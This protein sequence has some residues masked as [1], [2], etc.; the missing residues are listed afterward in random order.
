ME[1]GSLI[2]RRLDN[3]VFREIRK[4]DKDMQMGAGIGN[5]YS[6]VEGMIVADGTGD[7]PLISWTKAL[8]NYSCSMGAPAGARITMMLP[9]ATKES[10]IKGCMEEY[11]QLATEC[12]I[13]I[14]GGHTQVSDS[15]KNPFFS[16][17][18]F[19]RSEWHPDKKTVADGSGIVM[20]GYAGALGTDIL[21]RDNAELIRNRFGNYFS[22][23]ASGRGYSV[24]EAAGVAALDAAGVAYVHDIS[25]GG[26]YAALWQLGRWADCGFTVYND[27]IAINQET[28]EVCEALDKNPYLID[29]TGGLLIVTDDPEALLSAMDEKGI[30]ARLIG[31]IQ[32]GGERVVVFGDNEQRTL[33]ASTGD[34][35]WKETCLDR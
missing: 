6:A 15:F 28:I 24:R 20:C 9:V 11:Q 1:I 22:K 4:I 23:R 26:V 7:T 16:V 29:G 27:R 33:A 17:Q 13:Q 8:N 2:E 19:G 32:K 30:V 31:R 14:A 25:S 10:F 5:D 34:E 35:I 12:G 18:I 21:L 3:A